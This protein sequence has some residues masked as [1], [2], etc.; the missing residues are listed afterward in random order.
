MDTVREKRS[1]GRHA[2]AAMFALAVASVVVPATV[3]TVQRH[4][5]QPKDTPSRHG[6]FPGLL[7]E[8]LGRKSDVRE[9]V[10]RD[11]LRSYA[12][13][14]EVCF[15][16]FGTIQDLPDGYIDLFADLKL[17]IKKVSEA[18]DCFW[19]VHDKAT[20][21][22]GAIFTVSVEEMIDEKEAVLN[23]SYWKGPLS[24]CGYKVRMVK[25]GEQWI[26]KDKWD[27]CVS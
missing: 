9:P 25:E 19:E 7:P 14:G 27:E 2:I 22:R 11:L 24:G 13:Q 8:P 23:A 4:L 5:H 6:S 21:K 1:G 10:F 17:T 26:A 15:L 3:S 18:E 20:G 16:S 12:E